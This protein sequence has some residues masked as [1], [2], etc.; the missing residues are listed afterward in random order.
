LVRG[1]CFKIRVVRG[2]DHLKERPNEFVVVQPFSRS[3]II[4]AW[5]EDDVDVVRI[6]LSCYEAAINNSRRT[7]DTLA[8]SINNNNSLISASRS[9]EPNPNRAANSWTEQT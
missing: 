5:Q 1:P 7:P 9:S 6:Q 2:D 4:G 8:A 3:R